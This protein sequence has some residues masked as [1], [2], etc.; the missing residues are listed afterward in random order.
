MKFRGLCI[1]RVLGGGGILTNCPKV[2]SLINL[3]FV[4]ERDHYIIKITLYG[5]WKKNYKHSCFILQNFDFRVGQMPPKGTS[6]SITLDT[7]YPSA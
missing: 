4:S 7:G 2:I 6:K 3:I 5:K 1:L